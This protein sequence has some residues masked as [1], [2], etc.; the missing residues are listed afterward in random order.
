MEWIKIKEQPPKDYDDVIISDGESVA[1]AHLGDY[2][3]I[4]TK[5]KG[6]DKR[7]KELTWHVPHFVDAEW[8]GVCWL[9]EMKEII[10][11]MPLPNIPSGGKI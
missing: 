3:P 10:Y 6:W 4:D 11:W 7:K 8:T 2:R 5:K 1:V 9:Q